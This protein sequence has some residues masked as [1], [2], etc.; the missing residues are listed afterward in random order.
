MCTFVIINS[1]NDFH[2]KI[3]IQ[4][5]ANM[6]LYSN[7]VLR[8]SLNSLKSRAHQRLLPQWLQYMY[9][10]GQAAMVIQLR[11]VR[12]SDN[13]QHV[14]SDKT[15]NFMRQTCVE[16]YYQNLWHFRY[17]DRLPTYMYMTRIKYAKL[18]NPIYSAYENSL[19]FINL[20]AI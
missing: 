15:P 2:K 9:Q 6:K 17:T 1:D 18:I 5:A 10:S 16:N 12:L 11:R 8:T 13:T 20:D 3:D 19:W 4:D 7:V 14:Y